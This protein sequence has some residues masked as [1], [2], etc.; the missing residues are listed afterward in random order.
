[1]IE[2]GSETECNHANNASLNSMSQAKQT[3]ENDTNHAWGDP[4]MI[5]IGPTLENDADHV[6]AMSLPVSPDYEKQH[7]SLQVTPK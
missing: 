4:E 2:Q 7:N 1:M 3:F 5:P 6:W